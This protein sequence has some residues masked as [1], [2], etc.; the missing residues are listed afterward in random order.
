MAIAFDHLFICTAKNASEV[1]HILADG[2]TEETS[3]SHPGQGTT[4]CD[5]G[6]QK[7]T[8]DFSP[9]LPLRLCW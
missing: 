1:D 6:V 3:N 2:F 8:V 5:R 4:N 7:Q 9:H